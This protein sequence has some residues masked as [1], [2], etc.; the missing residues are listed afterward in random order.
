MYPFT[1][2]SRN[3]GKTN[4][5]TRKLKIMSSEFSSCILFSAESLWVKCYNSDLEFHL[6]VVGGDKL[7]PNTVPIAM[8]WWKC[9]YT[10]EIAP[11]HTWDSCLFALL[12]FFPFKMSYEKGLKTR[13]DF[14][15]CML[16]FN[17]HIFLA[18]QPEAIEISQNTKSLEF[19]YV[20]L[21]W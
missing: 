5:L 2:R 17:L 14:F 8:F 7:Q 13:H 3:T 11:G 16:F 12:D 19:F 6:L 1:F 21:K 9:I 15:L 4:P 10:K 20:K 18:E